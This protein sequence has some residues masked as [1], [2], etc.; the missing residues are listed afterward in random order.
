MYCPREGEDRRAQLQPI[1]FTMD[2]Q[3][4]QQVAASSHPNH[5]NALTHQAT[6]FVPIVPGMLAI[7]NEMSVQLTHS[8]CTEH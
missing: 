8:R 4:S 3:A 7:E 2:V 5:T 6:V 1:P